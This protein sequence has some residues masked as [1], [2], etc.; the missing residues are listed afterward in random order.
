MGL[1]DVLCTDFLKVGK[2]F[3]HCCSLKEFVNLKK[4]F[5]VLM[6]IFLPVFRVTES[7]DTRY[8]VIRDVILLFMHEMCHYIK[9]LRPLYASY[10]DSISISPVMRTRRCEY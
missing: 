6:K 9:V 1:L 2:Y 8:F 10:L 5:F 7:K 3:R 4:F